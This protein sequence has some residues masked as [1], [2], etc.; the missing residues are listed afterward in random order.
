[1]S[2]LNSLVV[3]L[4][5]AKDS[6]VFEVSSHQKGSERNVGIFRYAGQKGYFNVKLMYGLVLNFVASFRKT[7]H[8]QLRGVLFLLFIKT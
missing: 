3:L 6:C 1:M 5:F 4:I 8:L 7:A 2:N